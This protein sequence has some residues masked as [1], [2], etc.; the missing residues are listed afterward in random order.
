MTAKAPAWYLLNAITT[1]GPTV[2]SLYNLLAKGGPL[3]LAECR[4]RMDLRSTETE[5]HVANGLRWLHTI[6]L[7]SR[8][9]G[10]TIYEA[11]G[12]P[13]EG[14]R[15]MLRLVSQIRNAPG[16][17]RDMLK[18]YE[19]LL[20]AGRWKV[21]DQ[22]IITELSRRS[23]FT[24]EGMAFNEQKIRTWIRLFDYLGLIYQMPGPVQ[25]LLI[26]RANLVRETL[27]EAGA[28]EQS[29]TLADWIRLVDER[30]FALLN[31]DGLLHQG[32]ASV[33]LQM[34]AGNVV[35]LAQKDDAPQVTM[36]NQTFS[37]IQLIDEEAN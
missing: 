3:S 32:V 14:A 28:A 22:E 29:I 5:D 15:F 25:I 9:E 10:G 35:R 4:E 8:D 23:V 18:I 36:G 26:P 37:H 30:Y 7:V 1:N 6:G 11:T 13:A 31:D 17:N 2:E 34:K 16:D 21:T 12:T 19:H 24:P 20:R 33:L 27:V